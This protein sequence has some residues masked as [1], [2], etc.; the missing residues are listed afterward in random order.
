MDFTTYQQGGSDVI[1]EDNI[2][3]KI[4]DEDDDEPVI[5]STEDLMMKL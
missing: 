5:K 3:E 1:N 4:E 2:D